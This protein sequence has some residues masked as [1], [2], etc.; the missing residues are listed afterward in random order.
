MKGKFSNENKEN[1]ESIL[2][3]TKDEKEIMNKTA[4]LVHKTEGEIKNEVKLKRGENYIKILSDFILTKVI[5]VSV[6]RKKISNN[7]LI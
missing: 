1:E 7:N 3:K 5:T 2:I 6:A 4:E